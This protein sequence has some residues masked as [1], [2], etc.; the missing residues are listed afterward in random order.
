MLVMKFVDVSV[1]VC[2]I[3]LSIVCENRLVFETTL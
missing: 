1:T 3:T 2:D